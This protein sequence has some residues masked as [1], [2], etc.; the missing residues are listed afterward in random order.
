[1]GGAEEYLYRLMSGLDREKYDVRFVCTNEKAVEP[2]LR[3]LGDLG[4]KTFVLRAGERS[5]RTIWR[6]FRQHPTDIVH[7]NLTNPFACRYAIIAAKFAGVP[8]IITT[9]HLATIKPTTY[10]WKG[11]LVL[12]I[13]NQLVD[14]TIVESEINRALAMANYHFD[15]SKV[16]TI[17]YGI[18]LKQ[19]DGQPSRA[20]LREFGIGPDCTIVGTIGR[21]SPQKTQDDFLRA[22]AKV[23]DA[24]PKTKF[25]IVGE[26]ELRHVL[27]ELAKHF[28]L[29]S[30][31]IFTGYRSDIA[32]LLRAFDVFVL[33]S[34][35][36]GLPLSILEAMA[37]AKPVVATHVD[38]VPE[39]VSDGETGLLVPPGNPAALAGAIVSLLQNPTRAQAMGHAGR[40]RAETLFRQE[41]M[42]AQ[43]EPLYTRLLKN[44]S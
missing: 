24:V 34:I 44:R 35:F 3:R 42:V 27:E 5:L 14:I 22:A 31:V 41:R 17:H 13:A 43:T 19:F 10:T 4:V 18:D 23:K 26:G 7:C 2:L 8:V 16:I 25:F 29:Q 37:M 36:E 38:G 30:D 6:F 9:N 12:A 28:G 40:R 21:L 39:A 15:P 1:M 33:S 32:D 11:R 20:A